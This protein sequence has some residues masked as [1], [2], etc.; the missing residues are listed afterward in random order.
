MQYME[1][2]IQNFSPTA[3]CFA[4]LMSPRNLSTIVINS[5]MVI[6]EKNMIFEDW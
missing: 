1:E 5:P 2:D 6:F 3:H 4:G